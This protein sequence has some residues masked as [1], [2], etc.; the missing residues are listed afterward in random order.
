MFSRPAY[1][2]Y[3]IHL[4][5]TAIDLP[6]IQHE[7]ATPNAVGLL[8][9]STSL[10]VCENML[11]SEPPTS[12]LPRQICSHRQGEPCAIP[13]P[14]IV[15]PLIRRMATLWRMNMSARV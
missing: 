1:R 14:T 3:P 12:K 10:Q 4:P 11:R 8:T 9:I 2:T 7:D 15:L 6:C 13:I 5:G